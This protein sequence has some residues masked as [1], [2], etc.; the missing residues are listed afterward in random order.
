LFILQLDA[1]VGSTAEVSVTGLADVLG[2]KIQGSVSW[3]FDFGD[4]KPALATV[5]VSGLLLSAS[6]ATI[7]NLGGFSAIDADLATFLGVPFFRVDE[8]TAAP[9]VVGGASFTSIQLALTA[10][11]PKT[12]TIL[13]QQLAQQLIQLPIGNNAFSSFTSALK[14]ASPCQ[15]R[16]NYALAMLLHELAR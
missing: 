16:V 6:T 9:I 4:Y 3:S 11:S 2:N 5:R 1:L 13:A 12:A 15:V 8:I 14:F 7:K 10:G